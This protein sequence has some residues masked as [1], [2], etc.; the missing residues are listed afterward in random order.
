MIRTVIADDQPQARS[1]LRLVLE[2]EGDFAVVGEA[3]D[4]AD[5]MDVV[6]TTRPDLVVLDYRMPNVDGLQAA[7]EIGA[8]DPDISIVLWTGEDD[9]SIT[10]AAAEAGIHTA[11]SKSGPATALPPALRAAARSGPSSGPR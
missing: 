3:V 10:D 5:V 9:P 11:L 2:A 4:G 1:I 7:R 6:E 8:R